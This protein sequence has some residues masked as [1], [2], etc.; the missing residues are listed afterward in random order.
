[1]SPEYRFFFF[2]IECKVALGIVAQERKKGDM[3]GAVEIAT[4]CHFSMRNKGSRQGLRSMYN[5]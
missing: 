4:G 3:Q 1:M 2:A 5:F